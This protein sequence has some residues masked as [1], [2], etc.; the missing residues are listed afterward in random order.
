M[1]KVIQILPSISLESGGISHRR[2]NVKE[3][4][5]CPF[6]DY[7]FDESPH[8]VHHGVT[9]TRTWTIVQNGKLNTEMCLHEGKTKLQPITFFYL[10]SQSIR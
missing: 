5:T 3:T 7:C 2:H 1:I 8:M 4:T 10:N 9:F 6:L